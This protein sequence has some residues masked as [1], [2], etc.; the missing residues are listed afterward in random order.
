MH[1]TDV[2]YE[3]ELGVAIKIC[4]NKMK[5]KILKI[6]NVLIFLQCYRFLGCSSCSEIQAVIFFL[7]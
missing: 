6:E 7:F 3:N 4:K 5:G 1:F 2:E